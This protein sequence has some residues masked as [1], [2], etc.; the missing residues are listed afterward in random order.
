MLLKRPNSQLR[1]KPMEWWYCGPL[2]LAII[3]F[4]L[5]GTICERRIE[6]AIRRII[7]R[8]RAL[9]PPLPP[10]VEYEDVSCSTTDLPQESTP[11]PMMTPS[12]R[13]LR[14]SKTDTLLVNDHRLDVPIQSKK[15]VV[16]T[17]C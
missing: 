16:D 11:P 2:V 6:A 12:Q 13:T 5:V 3:M 17:A 4:L 7:E 15:L 9:L 14:A 8:R 10:P 1:Q